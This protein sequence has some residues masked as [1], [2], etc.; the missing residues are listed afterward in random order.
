MIKPDKVRHHRAKI[1]HPSHRTL[2]VILGGSLV[3]NEVMSSAEHEIGK[4]KSRGIVD[5]FR[6]R[7]TLLSNLE[8]APKVG[9]SHQ[10]GE[11][12]QKK[13]KFTQWVS[14]CLF[15]NETPLN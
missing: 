4:E 2:A 12:R 7:L 13:L 5:A 15:K 11:L 3:P 6:E 10:K 9:K 8:R 1:G 14:K